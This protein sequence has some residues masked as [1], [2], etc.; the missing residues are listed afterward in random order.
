MHR[1][2]A[3][4]PFRGIEQVGLNVEESAL[5]RQE[6]SFN[7]R[8]MDEVWLLKLQL[9]RRR[10][11]IESEASITQEVVQGL[12]ANSNSYVRDALIR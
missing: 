6:Y 5:P 11:R 7:L 9:D 12:T 2:A 1:R 3:S 10:S 8:V 4:P